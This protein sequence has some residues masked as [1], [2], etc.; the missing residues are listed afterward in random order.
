M[1]DAA[2]TV[3]AFVQR[4]D[5]TSDGKGVGTKMYGCVCR[6]P[7]CSVTAFQSRMAPHAVW[8]CCYRDGALRPT[9]NHK[10]L[11]AQRLPTLPSLR[12]LLTEV[13]GPGFDARALAGVGGSSAIDAFD[14]WD[15]QP[16][17]KSSLGLVAL[18]LL[19]N[20]GGPFGHVRFAM[21][22]AFHLALGFLLLV[23]RS[24][25]F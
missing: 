16:L 3:P 6:I 12:R 7:A 21:L 4:V 18:V 25:S 17:H 15:S 5:C 2:M 10:R 24:L 20:D 19:D 1:L 14:L 13:G 11:P 23:I 9:V 22:D 8:L